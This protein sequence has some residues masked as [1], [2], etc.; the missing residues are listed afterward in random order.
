MSEELKTALKEDAI[1]TVLAT[2]AILLLI[3]MAFGGPV[4]GR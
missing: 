4:L 1:K 3:Y 2:G